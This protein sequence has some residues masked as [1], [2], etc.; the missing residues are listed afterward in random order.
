[1][2]RPAARFVFD[3]GPFV[4]AHGRQP[5]GYGCWAF[6]SGRRSGVSA[7]GVVDLFPFVWV[8]PP[9]SFAAARSHAAFAAAAAGLPSGAV[10]FVLP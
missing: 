10:L 5:R 2:V 1:V 3:P 4:A 6:G 7:A 9:L 8:S